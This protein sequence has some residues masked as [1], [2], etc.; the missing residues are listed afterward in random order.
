MFP[1]I[2]IVIYWWNMEL[3]IPMFFINLDRFFPGFDGTISTT[4]KNRGRQESL[5]FRTHFCLR[6]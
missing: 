1:T 4:S 3:R 5:E 6:I 2:C